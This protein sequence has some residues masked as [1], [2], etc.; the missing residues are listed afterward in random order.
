ME[1][2]LRKDHR[3][4]RTNAKTLS[5]S[6]RLVKKLKTS[7][8]QLRSRVTV[9]AATLLYCGVEKEYKQAKVKAAQILG[10]HFLPSNRN[11]TLE[12]DRI[13]EEHEGTTRKMHL[14]LMRKYAMNIMTTL[15]AYCPLLIGSVWRGTPRKGSD[16]D[17]AVY[18]DA[19]GEILNVLELRGF[20]IYTKERVTVTKKGKT[21]AS[22]HINLTLGIHKVE[23]VVRNPEEVNMQR[24]CEVFGDKITG[25]TIQKLT[26]VLAENPTQKFLPT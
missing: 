3:I 16:I 2:N 12:L 21:E 11:V 13:I 26:K 14:F 7:S 19:P 9:E 10:T 5:A 24:T 23:I 4:L 18:H 6:Q 8:Q 22:F 17:I 15:K 20:R 25:L 1:Q